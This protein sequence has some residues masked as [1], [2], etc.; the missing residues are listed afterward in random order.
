MEDDIYELI[1]KI[2][3]YF[4]QFVKAQE[5]KTTEEIAEEYGIKLVNTRKSEDNFVTNS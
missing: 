4:R 5:G 2:D 3:P 1:Y